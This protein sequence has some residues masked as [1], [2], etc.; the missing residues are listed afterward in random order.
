MF[1]VECFLIS[2]SRL[3]W[4][5]L[6]HKVDEN[7]YEQIETFQANGAQPEIFVSICRENLI[8]FGA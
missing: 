8:K 7:F 6:H 2:P 4:I 1:H 5:A 3:L